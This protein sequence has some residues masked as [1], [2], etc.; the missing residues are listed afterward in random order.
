MAEDDIAALTKTR[1]MLVILIATCQQT[2]LALGAVGNV[3]DVGLTH[4]LTAMIERSERELEALRIKI[5][6]FA[7]S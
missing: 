7:D 5:G 3:L 4:D 6:S 1:N 2:S